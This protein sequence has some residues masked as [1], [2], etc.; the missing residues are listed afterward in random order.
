MVVAMITIAI[1]SCFIID[2][3]CFVDLFLKDEPI[4][5]QVYSRK[6]RRKSGHQQT[7]VYGKQTA[8]V[9]LTV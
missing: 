1:M 7:T 5:V 6:T 4:L 9:G 2:S 3:F 8:A